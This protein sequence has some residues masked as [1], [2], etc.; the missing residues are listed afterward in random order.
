VVHGRGGVLSIKENESGHHLKRLLLKEME[1][2]NPEVL[3]V[4]RIIYKTPN[5]V[6]HPKIRMTDEPFQ[7][8]AS[9]SNNYSAKNK[10][11]FRINKQKSGS[12][13]P[14]FYVFVSFFI[15]FSYK[16]THEGTHHRTYLFKGLVAS[17]LIAEGH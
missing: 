16:C 1:E 10:C 12:G 17:M 3:Y 15:I 4:N 6:C 8:A 7:I 9:N 14:L 5:I 13:W 2:F 11:E